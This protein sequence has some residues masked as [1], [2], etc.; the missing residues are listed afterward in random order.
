MQRKDLQPVSLAGLLIGMFVLYGYAVTMEP[1][2][3]SISEIGEHEGEYVIV[4]GTVLEVYDI[5]GGTSAVMTIAGD[6]ATV[7]IYLDGGYGEVEI[8]D[9]VEVVGLVARERDG[10]SISVSMDSS[11]RIVEHWESDTRTLPAIAACPWNH[12]HMNVNISCRIR[13][14]LTDEDGYSYMLVEDGE[15][16][17]YSMFVTVF[18]VSVQRG[19]AGQSV[20]VCT[21]LEYDQERL[22]FSGIMDS[23][24]HHIWSVE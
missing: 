20:Y 2:R 4:R 14:P 15:L 21:R 22:S 7:T 5:G 9:I 16:P 17:E 13:I 1:R 18:G 23:G 10:Y 6:N 12:M 24:E 19:H 3:I 8:S 11:L